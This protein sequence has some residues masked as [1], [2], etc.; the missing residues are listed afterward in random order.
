MDKKI[1]QCHVSEKTNTEY[2]KQIG[3]NYDEKT[4]EI[5]GLAQN[6]LL[7]RFNGKL[8]LLE[9]GVGGGESLKKIARNTADSNSRIF[10]MDLF[11]EVLKLIDKEDLNIE[12]ISANMSH[13]PIKSETVSGV[14]ASSIFHEV[15]SYGV[16]CDDG[17]LYGKDA[18]KVAFSEL[19]R[20]L[21]HNGC[22]AY[23]DVS[24][25]IGHGEEVERV[26]YYGESWKEFL[27]W[28]IDD[29][30]MNLRVDFYNS[31]KQSIDKIDNNHDITIE[32]SRNLHRETQR[33]YL[34]FRDYVINNMQEI[35]GVKVFD[36]EWV[37]KDNGEKKFRVSLSPCANEYGDE[38]KKTLG[39]GEI[40]L[41]SIQFDQLIDQIMADALSELNKNSL[42][43][44]EFIDSANRWKNREAAEAYIYGDYLDL[45]EMSIEST[46]DS[47][48][49]TVLFP[50]KV[51]DFIRVQRTYYNRYLK[52]RIDNPEQDAKQMI[53][54]YKISFDEAVLVINEIEIN[55]RFSDQVEKINNIKKLLLSKMV[56]K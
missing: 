41:D 21:M 27:R 23:R 17:M 33:H 36:S 47:D 45:L 9:I 54:F 15:S 19:N 56:N 50:K 51:D 39:F 2:I 46:L 13:I 25:P 10:G 29:F 30:V 28:F 44:I 5:I 53:N 6:D 31:E 7:P 24:A 52:S 38:I 32:M 8:N 34:M 14:N 48:Q 40:V 3:N 1:N 42:D 55:S 12:L 22:V 11:P 26:T 18:I 16:E 43:A 35:I 49:D 20:I 37:N 4:A